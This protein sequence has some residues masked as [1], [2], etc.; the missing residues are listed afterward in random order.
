MGL[1]GQLGEEVPP[2]YQVSGKWGAPDV[3]WKGTSG[4]LG[5]GGRGDVQFGVF[6]LKSFGHIQEGTPHEPW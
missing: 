3:V 5:R 1:A 4:K 6:G 2:T